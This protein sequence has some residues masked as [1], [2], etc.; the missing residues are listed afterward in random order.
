MEMQ[1]QIFYCEQT[2]TQIFPYGFPTWQVL[3][4]RISLIW[5]QRNPDRIPDPEIDVTPATCWPEYETISGYLREGYF[6]ILNY[7]IREFAD[8]R[9]A[10]NCL[11]MLKFW[12][13]ADV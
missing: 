9:E 8:V 4:Q 12:R 3:A 6:Q 7:L 1:M 2:T 13:L 5:Q 10:L 11:I